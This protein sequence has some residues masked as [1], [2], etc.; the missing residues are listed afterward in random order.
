MQDISSTILMLCGLASGCTSAQ[1]A[2]GDPSDASAESGSFTGYSV[3]RP[4]T[5]DDN[6]LSV[7]G[8]GNNVTSD[9]VTL[10][11][12]YVRPRLFAVR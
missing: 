9:L 4:C 11:G 3:T 12:T 7:R 5:G 6:S 8:T 10:T 1:G 2:A